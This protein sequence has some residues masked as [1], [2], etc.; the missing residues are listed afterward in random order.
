MKARMRRKPA[1]DLGR[2]VGGA[3]VEDQVQVEIGRRFLVDA[4]D[5]GLSIEK[6]YTTF[7]N[8]WRFQ[9][10]IDLTSTGISRV[11]RGAETSTLLGS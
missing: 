11:N 3:V 1:P 4:F 9:W 8:R 2:L 7:W 5:F 10:H 6:F